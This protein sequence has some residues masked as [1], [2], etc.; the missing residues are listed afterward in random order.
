MADSTLRKS[1][2]ESPKRTQTTPATTP[3]RKPRRK[4][5]YPLW[6]HTGTG[7]WAK[8]IKGRVY[9]FG[10]NK[11]AALEEYL[12]VKDDR[13]AGRDPPPKDEKRVTLKSRYVVPVESLEAF[14]ERRTVTP[15]SAPARRRA[16]VRRS[17][18]IEFIK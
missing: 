3:A 9:Y 4:P 12:R 1:A 14:E 8:K 2:A 17:D 11:D 13:E 16:K 6:L 10:T 5:K 7:Q 15:P 18:V